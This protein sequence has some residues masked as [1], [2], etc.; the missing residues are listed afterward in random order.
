MTPNRM[1]DPRLLVGDVL[2]RSGRSYVVSGWSPRGKL[3]MRRQSGTT[4][5]CW[6]RRLADPPKSYE[7]WRDGVCVR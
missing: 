1:E 7:V 4:M 6:W 3:T 2:K 5:A